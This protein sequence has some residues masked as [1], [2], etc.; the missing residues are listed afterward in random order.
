[1]KSKIIALI[2]LALMAS[3]SFAEKIVVFDPQRA[4]LNTKLAQSKLQELNSNS[5]FS[6]LRTNAEKLKAE[7]QS[8]AKDSETNGLTW[9]A[10]K[11]A[12]VKKKAEYIQADLQLAVKKLQAEE[13]VVVKTLIAE[14]QPKV[15]VELK[16][17]I[18]SEGISIILRAESI[19]HAVEANDISDKV[20][21]ALDKSK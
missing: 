2:A 19:Y 20:T 12:E 6:A 8:L 5:E 18:E 1:M 16:K 9:S 11:Q 4:M 13:S 15:R 17:I 7:L 10:E 14:L 3:S 21:K